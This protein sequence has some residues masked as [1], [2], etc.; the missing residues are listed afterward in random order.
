MRR[1]GFA[2]LAQYLYCAA[3]YCAARA[4]VT[5]T[6]RSYPLDGN[7]RSA[8]F[9]DPI[10]K[11]DFGGL[12]DSGQTGDA[13]GEPRV[14]RRSRSRSSFQRTR[15][16]TIN[17]LR[18][19]DRIP[20]RPG[21]ILAIR[22]FHVVH[23]MCLLSN[24]PGLAD[25]L[26]AS[27][28][29]SV[30]KRGNV[31][32]KI[33]E[34]F[35][36]T[37]F[38]RPVF[39]RVVDVAP[40]VGFRRSWYRRKA[41]ATYFLTVQALHRGEL[42]FA[43]YDLANRGRRNVPSCQGCR[44]EALI[45]F[46]RMVKERSVRF[47]FRSG[48][49]SG[50]TLV[51]LGQPWSNLVKL[52][53]N[54]PNPGKYPVLR[55]FGVMSP[56]GSGEAV[57]CVVDLGMVIWCDEPSS[58]QADLVRAVSFCVP[59]PEKIP[60]VKMGYCEKSSSVCVS[61]SVR[62]AG[63]QPV[64]TRVKSLAQISRSGSPFALLSPRNG[65]E[66]GMNRPGPPRS[67][68]EI[69]D[70]GPNR[71]GPPSPRNGDESG[72]N[73]SGPPSPRNE[74]CD[75]G[76]NRSGPPSPRNG[77][78]SGTNRPGP[79]R[80]RNEICDS[81]PN[82]SGP[83]SPRNGDESGTNRPGPSRSRNEICDS[84]PNRS[85][86]PSPRNGDESG[87]NRPGPSRS[88]NEICDSGPNRSGP[89]SPRNGDESGTNRPGPPR[90][91]NEICDSGP[92]RSGPPSPRN[93]DESGTNRPGP[94]RSRNE[95]CDSG[96]NRSGPPS[97]RNG[98]ESGTNRSGHPALETK[99]VIRVRIGLVHPALETETNRERIGLV[100]PDVSSRGS[101]S[102]DHRRSSR[103]GFLCHAS[104]IEVVVALF[105]GSECTCIPYFRLS[106]LTVSTS[107]SAECVY[108]E[109]FP[110]NFLEPLNTT[111]GLVEP[112]RKN[113]PSI[114]VETG[115]WPS[116][117][118]GQHSTKAS[119]WDC[120][121]AFSGQGMLFEGSLG[122]K[123]FNIFQ[124]FLASGLTGG[125]EGEMNFIVTLVWPE[126]HG[127]KWTVPFM[128][129]DLLKLTHGQ[130]KLG[131]MFSRTIIY[132][133]V[134]AAVGITWESLPPLPVVLGYHLKLPPRFSLRGSSLQSAQLMPLGL[135]CPPSSLS[136]PHPRLFLQ[137]ESSSQG[138]ATANPLF[139]SKYGFFR[140]STKILIISF[141][142]RRGHAR[143]RHFFP[144][145][146]YLGGNVCAKILSDPLQL[147]PRAKTLRQ[148]VHFSYHT[149]LSDHQELLR[150]SR[151]LSQ[152]MT[153]WH[154]EHSNGLRSQDHILRTQARLCARPVP[155]ENRV[156]LTRN[157]LIHKPGCVGKKTHSCTT[158][159][160]RIAK[161]L[162]G[163]AG[164]LIGKLPSNGPKTLRWPLFA[165]PYL[166]SQIC[167]RTGTRFE[168]K[169]AGRKTHFSSR[170]AAFARRVFPARN[171]LIYEPG[172]VG[173]IT[174]PATSWNSRFAESIPR[175]IGIFTGK[176]HENS[177][178]TPTSG[179]HN[180]LIRTPI[181]GKL[182]TVGKRT[183][184]AF[185]RYAA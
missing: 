159:N 69:C 184:R 140:V 31:G 107:M 97:P 102:G 54:S 138:T 176:V 40:D 149:Q 162:S 44:I 134:A 82:R 68:N 116:F 157:K 130:S 160:S 30:R 148:E 60:G 127:A 153:P 105:V 179:S 43:R 117:S 115:A 2:R 24:V 73:R 57:F 25:Q 1:D 3:Q 114:K 180:S 126:G 67:R 38:R 132:L 120:V 164:I 18:F 87:T 91:R 104:F 121:W 83:P 36:K 53:Q 72:T 111:H 66:S 169:R 93:G 89:P 141:S 109:R 131:N 22:E 35:S 32:G 92:N 78:E 65:D 137:Q 178:D 80:S 143:G 46:F 174:T 86:P 52:G 154:K 98:D 152:K 49:W 100:H 61:F 103:L 182:R 175:L 27:Q 62:R 7:S 170:T 155:L 26:V 163:S 150:S 16:R 112:R 81:G 70:S 136:S 158:W 95:I 119:V 88:R 71:S 5:A 177:S 129:Y 145:L 14:A 63:S 90:S 4:T 64:D 173:K 58:D 161:N 151:N 8:R 6:W 51:K 133:D 122:G 168:E 29:D 101:G 146:A 79:S 96:P 13:T 20:A 124:G 74:I 59:T 84:G 181:Q 19:S 56:V 118:Y 17:L 23:G 110:S 55:L 185:R 41:Y 99:F 167:A 123:C 171:K 85:G 108:D 33:P 47:S 113:C 48:Q 128:R 144:P 11:G 77:D 10:F 75:S 172:C 15:A 165:E 106:Y 42:G 135:A 45:T 21:K 37:L 9:S 147:G 166:T 34:V 156:F 12:P 183:S 50:Q 39:T 94:S 76:P 28:E 139:D 125:L 142:S